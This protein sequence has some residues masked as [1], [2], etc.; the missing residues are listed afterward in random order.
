MPDAPFDGDLLV[1]LFVPHSEFEQMPLAL[2][3]NS[4]SLTV[5]IC[6]FSQVPG[7]ASRA[8]ALSTK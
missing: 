7:P 5:H 1:T 4:R 6:L 3:N 8:G 2:R